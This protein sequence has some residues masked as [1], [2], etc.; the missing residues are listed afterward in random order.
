MHMKEVDEEEVDEDGDF[1]HMAR[2]GDSGDDLSMDV[3]EESSI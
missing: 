2:G 1:F 3:D